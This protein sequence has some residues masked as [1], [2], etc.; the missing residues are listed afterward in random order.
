[1]G[2]RKIVDLQVLERAE[3]LSLV[4]SA[5]PVFAGN[6]FAQVG[7]RLNEP[8]FAQRNGKHWRKYR[9]IVLRPRCRCTEKPCAPGE[10]RD[11]LLRLRARRAAG[12]EHHNHRPSE[13]HQALPRREGSN[14]IWAWQRW[15]LSR[16]PYSKLVLATREV[17]T[18]TSRAC[19][20]LRT[21]WRLLRSESFSRNSPYHGA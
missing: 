16:Q 20:I 6:E 10:N 13:L 3:E 15:E 12:K 19:H 2:I 14:A 9:L 17:V 18:G 11:S 4:R 5:G 1:M 7:A 8:L 21:A